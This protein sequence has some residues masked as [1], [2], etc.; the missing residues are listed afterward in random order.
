[1]GL[2][3]VGFAINALARDEFLSMVGSCRGGL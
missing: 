3:E 1:M 2:L